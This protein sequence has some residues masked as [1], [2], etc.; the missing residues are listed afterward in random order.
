M[1][2]APRI[3]KGEGLIRT[4]DLLEHL[5]ADIDAGYEALERERD[6]QYL[7]RC[8]VRAIFSYIEAVIEC[9]KVEVRSTIRTDQYRGALTDR[10]KEALGPL[11]TMGAKPGRFLPLEQ[12]PKRT[13]ELAAKVWMLD[14]FELQTSGEAHSSFLTAK[15]ARNRL[16]HPK[17]YYDIEVTDLDMHYHTVAGMWVQAQFKRLFNA[18]VEKLLSDLGRDDAELLRRELKGVRNGGSEV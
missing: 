13:F 5:R 6:S 4:Y 9:I 7:R 15:N 12:N 8:V 3:A 11:T 17:T 1:P 18:R 2:G 14:E 16:T 10:E